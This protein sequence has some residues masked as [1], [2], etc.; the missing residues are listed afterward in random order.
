MFLIILS[1]SISQV[2]ASDWALDKTS[3][4]VEFYY[5]VG[6]CNGQE[7]VFLKI[8]NKNDYAVSVSFTEEFTDKTSGRNIESFSGEKQ[9]TIASGKTLQANS[10]SDTDCSEC[11]ILLSMVTPTH[12]IEMQKFTYSIVS[13]S[14]L[15]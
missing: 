5:K 2:T 8:V 14:A 7:A 3:N 12:I 9:L 6:E 1:G 4:N 11:V 10:C 13:V 15:R